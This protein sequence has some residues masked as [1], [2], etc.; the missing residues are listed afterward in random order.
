[1]PFFALIIPGLQL[2][3]ILLASTSG[4]L[5]GLQSGVAFND[6]SWADHSQIVP[7]AP[8]GSTPKVGQHEALLPRIVELLSL[9]IDP[10]D[11]TIE[12]NNL[13]ASKHCDSLS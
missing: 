12:A 4:A 3:V 2:D 8:A 11:S 1:M 7:A 10:C 9:V 5:R 13:L 6:L